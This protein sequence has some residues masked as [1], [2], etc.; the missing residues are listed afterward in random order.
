MHVRTRLILGVVS[1]V[2]LIPQGASATCLMTPFDR[3]VRESDAVLVGT[4]VD[5]GATREQGIVIRL[6]IEQVLMTLDEEIAQA[7]EVLALP[8]PKPPIVGFG[9]LHEGVDLP[10]WLWPLVGA[11]ILL[12][13]G[14]AVLL[15]R[16]AVRHRESR[17]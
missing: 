6:R 5:A 9:R 15:L 13:V 16:R 1:A 14:G 12:V 2:L 4:V 17:A 3:V 7:R 8:E 11:A 10:W